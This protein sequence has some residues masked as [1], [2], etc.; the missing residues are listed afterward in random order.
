MLEVF[1][2]KAW[3]DHIFS[4]D[5]VLLWLAEGNDGG[6]IAVGTSLSFGNSNLG[7]SNLGMQLPIK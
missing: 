7:S 2:Q 3:W 4:Y 5:K 1:A 6:N